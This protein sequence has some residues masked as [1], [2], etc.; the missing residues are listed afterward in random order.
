MMPLDCTDT[1]KSHHPGG[2]GPKPNSHYDFVTIGFLLSTSQ[3]CPWDIYL[4]LEIRYN[5]DACISGFLL[6]CVPNRRGAASL[7]A[8]LSCY[9]HHSQKRGRGKLSQQ[10][11]LFSPELWF[12]RPAQS[13]LL[14]PSTLHCGIPGVNTNSI[15]SEA[16][17]NM[18]WL[19]PINYL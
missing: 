7:A 11:L 3:G 18:G 12:F 14:T 10:G 6:V 13:S 16:T 9:N 1:S 5:L 15:P 19:Q 4:E 2:L 8:S 17:K